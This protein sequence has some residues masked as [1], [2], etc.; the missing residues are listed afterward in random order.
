MVLNLNTIAAKGDCCLAWGIRGMAASKPKRS[1]TPLD[2]E[3][4]STSLVNA[5]SA[6]QVEGRNGE[7]SRPEAA[8]LELEVSGEVCQRCEKV[9][10]PPVQ[11]V[12]H[13][14]QAVVAGNHGR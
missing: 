7:R 8:H 2:G 13:D 6:V 5:V 14:L 9:L 11:D 4:L 3:M 10:Q 12:R 1:S